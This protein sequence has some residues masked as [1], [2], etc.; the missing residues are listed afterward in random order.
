[1]I[2]Q[3]FDRWFSQAPRRVLLAGAG[4]GFDVVC[5]VPLALAL[6]RAGHHVE[7]VSASFTSLDSIRPQQRLGK[8]AW[9]AD[10]GSHGPAYFPEGALARWR[11]QRGETDRIYCLPMTGGAAFIAAYAELAAS[12]SID[13]VVLVDGGVDALLAGHEVSLGTPTLDALSLMA[14][15]EL[16]IR[17]FLATT[18]FGAERHDGIAH[19]QALEAIAHLTAVNGYLGCEALVT[20]DPLVAA[21]VDCAQSVFAAHEPLK[22]SVVVSTLLSALRGEFGVR[23]VNAR[24]HAT[25]IWVSPLAALVFYFDL[26]AVARTKKYLPALAS[27]QSMSDANAV[28]EGHRKGGGIRGW[29]PIPI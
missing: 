7:L 25:P 1:V 28:I 4:G 8:Y 27:T 6:E 5:A 16:G 18:A 20:S 17:G 26:A 12:L 29:E 2:P 9:I 19:A 22:H 3:P 21:F 13:T 11:A 24:T 23:S 14:A 10:S 15:N